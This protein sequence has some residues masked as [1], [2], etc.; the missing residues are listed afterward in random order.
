LKIEEPEAMREIH[1][2]RRKHYE[3]TKN[4]TAEERLAYIKKKAR[5]FEEE[6]GIKLRRFSKTAR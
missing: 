3:E 6:S 2:I 5:E 1:E 4:M